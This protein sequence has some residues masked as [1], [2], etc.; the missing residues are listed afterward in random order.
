MVDAI[1]TSLIDQL[2]AVSVTGPRATGKTTTARRY[3]ATVV[4]LDREAEA[5]AFRAD[6]DVA[7]RALPEPVLL[8]EWQEVPGVLGAVKRAVDTNP[9]PGRYILTGSV[10]IDLDAQMW[11][12][13]GR[14]VRLPMQ[15]LSVRE[16]S[17][18]LGRPLFLDRLLNA[19]VESLGPGGKAD[20]ADYLDLALRGGFPEPA[21]RL[22]GLARQAWLES[23][24]DQL[25][26]RD[27]PAV[28]GARDPDRLRRYLEALAV[29]SAGVVEDKTLY[30]AVGINSRTANAYE[31]LLKNLL[32]LEALPAWESNRLS[33]LIRTPKRY[34]VDPS[35]MAAVM[36]LDAAAVLRDGNL[37]GRVIDTFV[38]AQIRPELAVAESRPRWYHLRDKGGRHEVDL[39]IEFGGRR[40]AG[41]EIKA[42]A[43]PKRN[44]VR[45]LE[46]L[47]DELG[48]RFVSGVV[49]HTGPRAYELADRV[50]AAP[51]STLW[52]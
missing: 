26:T 17:R 39:V 19:N 51:I 9:R 45:H 43:A 8:D 2:P 35:I 22:D 18:R 21:L 16:I 52:A 20:L 40:V 31:Q 27:A 44:D 28:A 30:D 7:L 11:P 25:I 15:G 48:D 46:W 41:I 37:L 42:N 5:A 49:L 29:N 6:P 38:A 23:Y 24:V 1:L 50:F 33:R 47:R 36:R 32:I 13:T 12:G 4:R 3:A 14:L 34:L 10:R